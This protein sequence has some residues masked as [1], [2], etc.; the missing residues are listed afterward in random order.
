M[1]NDLIDNESPFVGAMTRSAPKPW[2]EPMMTLSIDAYTRRYTSI[3]VIKLCILPR[4]HH[5]RLWHKS[6]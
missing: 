1:C 4:E 5:F 2:P 3:I 6:Y